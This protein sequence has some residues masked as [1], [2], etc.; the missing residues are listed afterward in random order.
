M[1]QCLFFT[2][3]C[4]VVRINDGFKQA[5]DLSVSSKNLVDILRPA[6]NDFVRMVIRP[7][8]GRPAFNFKSRFTVW[9]YGHTMIFVS[10]YGYRIKLLTRLVKKPRLYA[11]ISPRDIA[12]ICKHAGNGDIN[13]TFA[14]GNPL[15]E[16]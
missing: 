16:F 2:G 14:T 5:H 9:Q 4:P 8:P 10:I 15:A 13:I 3:H 1:Q 7:G 11:D 12:V 6:N